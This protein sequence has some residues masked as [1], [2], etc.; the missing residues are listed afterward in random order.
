M[1][2]PSTVSCFVP[3]AA[4]TSPSSAGPTPGAALA[5]LAG[6]AGHAFRHAASQFDLGGSAVSLSKRYRVIPSLSV[7]TL[8]SSLLSHEA[9]CPADL[10]LAA[11]LS[12][13][14]DEP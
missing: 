13:V 9:S 8:P 11:L 12:V 2:Q 4:G 10:A 3:S 6:T 14:P 5:P 1:G 7:S